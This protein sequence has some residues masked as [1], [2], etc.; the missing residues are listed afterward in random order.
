M[1]PV[2]EYLPV[3][4][5]GR[6]GNIRSLSIEWHI[7]SAEEI[8]ETTRIVRKFTKWQLEALRRFANGE[9]EDMSKE[10]LKRH[11]IVVDNLL[12]G[13]GSVLPFWTSSNS[14]AEDVTLIEDSVCR[15]RPLDTPECAPVAID[16]EG[17]LNV[18]LEV[19]AVM[20]LVQ[21]G[22]ASV[23]LVKPKHPAKPGFQWKFKNKNRKSG[24][25]GGDLEI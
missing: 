13:A 18:R 3:R 4:D 16:L 24:L 2:S 6:P 1:P 14:T 8:A 25:S 17:G 9:D 23:F 7:A 12:R 20:D 5:W 21:V 15:T 19:M 11:L 22:V 10:R